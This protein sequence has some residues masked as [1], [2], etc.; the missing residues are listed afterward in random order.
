MLEFVEMK[1]SAFVNQTSHADDLSA[2][3][4]AVQLTYVFLN[5]LPLLGLPHAAG[6]MFF[7]FTSKNWKIRASIKPGTNGKKS[8]YQIPSLD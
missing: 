5:M 8:R 4:L 1:P 3:Q 2:V 6:S 7:F